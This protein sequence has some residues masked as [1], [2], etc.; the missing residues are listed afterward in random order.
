MQKIAVCP[1]SFDP[2]TLGHVDVIT[3]AARVFD[4]VV[5]TVM[6]N[7]KKRNS[8]L[9]TPQE[10]VELIKKSVAHLPNV[11]VDFHSGL[12]ADYVSRIGA[13]AVVKGLRAV[14]DYED[15]FQQ[16]LT[17]K[18]LAPQVDTMFFVT[19]AEYMFLSSSLVRE[20]CS[21]GGDISAFVPAVIIEDI[22]KKAIIT[23]G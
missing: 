21:Y 16:A 2:I 1:G 10:R 22:K 13:V 14:S 7:S 18:R 15:E 19:S 12:L 4:K 6:Y 5:V 11:E 23:E 3:R 17:N 20:V 8:G 9:F